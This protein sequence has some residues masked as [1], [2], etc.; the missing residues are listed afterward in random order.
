MKR[1]YDSETCNRQLIV[2]VVKAE[3][4]LSKDRMATKQIETDT[5]FI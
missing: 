4:Q 3:L 5:E 1:F 2:A